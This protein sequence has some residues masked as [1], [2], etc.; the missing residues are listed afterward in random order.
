MNNELKSIWKEAMVKYFKILFRNLCGGTK[1]NNEGLQ[2]E[3]PVTGENSE[4]FFTKFLQILKLTIYIYIY[5]SHAA[6][7]T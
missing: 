2:P 6:R 1:E 3:Y 7:K 4:A 5:M